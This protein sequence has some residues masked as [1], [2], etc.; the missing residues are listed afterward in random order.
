[1][2]KKTAKRGGLLFIALLAL[3]AGVFLFTRPMLAPGDE[4]E[5]VMRRLDPSS[6]NVGET[7][8]TDATN[9]GVG[10]NVKASSFLIFDETTG[11]VIA[12]R[13]PDTPVA[14][15]S[16][17]KLMTALVT[18]K[19]G[20]LNDVW[21]INATSQIRINPV[22]GLKLGD[23]VMISDLIDSMLIGSANDA[24]ATL[25]AY[26]TATSGTEVT[27][28]M[29]KEA[30]N[31]GMDSTHYENPIGFDS[32][33]NYSTAND[34]KK[35]LDKIRTNPLFSSIDRKLS[36]S[37]TSETGQTYSIK[38]TNTLLAKDPEIHAIKTGFTDEAGGAMITAIHTDKQKF[39][40]IVLGSENRE[41][42][43]LLLKSQVLN[44]ATQ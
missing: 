35:L 1:M 32:E 21:E 37:F 6:R 33:Q 28:L 5:E 2:I 14:I 20:K 16:L 4:S 41:Q 31:L 34:L 38:A 7:Y 26:V 22:L 13:K 40:I 42:D 39:V 10:E 43:T 17:T 30:K 29:N 25:G 8:N 9:N 27:Q 24:A 19:Y 44:T 36:Y 18:E 11:Q 12:E 15:A 3:L 23:R